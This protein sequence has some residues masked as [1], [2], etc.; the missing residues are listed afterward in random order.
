MAT[1][2]PFDLVHGV[3]TA[4]FLLAL[5]GPWTRRIERVMCKYDVRMDRG[6]HVGLRAFSRRPF[7]L[8][9]C[10]CIVGMAIPDFFY[11]LRHARSINV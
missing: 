8:A 7:L 3:S 10:V 1:V 4:V 6:P 9:S 11:K 5:Y 2:V